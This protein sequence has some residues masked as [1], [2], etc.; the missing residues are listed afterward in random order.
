[1]PPPRIIV[2]PPIPDGVRKDARFFADVV[3]DAERRL[4]GP[5]LTWVLSWDVERLPVGGDDVVALV[6]GDEA[7]RRPPYAGDVLAT[8]KAYGDRPRLRRAEL[9]RPPAL[10][11]AIAVE[12]AR[13]RALALHDRVRARG[14]RGAEIHRLPLGTF[15]QVDLPMVDILERPVAVAFAGSV[16]APRGRAPSRRLPP[17][18]TTSRRAMLAGLEAFRARRPEARVAL[19]VTSAFGAPEAGDPIAYSRSLMD[20]RIC[21]VPRGG[22][23]ETF[24]F[25]EALRAGCVVVCEPLPRAWFYDGSPAVAL[26][27]WRRLPDVLERLLDDPAELRRRHEAGLAWWRERCSVPAVAAFVAARVGTALSRRP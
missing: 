14:R 8:F 1:V 15:N 17:A 23:V 10:A 3:L 19:Q 16:G 26:G 13:R 18:K 7:S 22:S 27:D 24:R 2:H 20:A 21:L 12:H 6:L 4:G 9:R 11:S 5:G 25:F